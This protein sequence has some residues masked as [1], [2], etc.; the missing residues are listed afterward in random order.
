V[1]DHGTLWA[2]PLREGA[3]RSD[4]PD[5]VFAAGACGGLLIACVEPGVRNT[6]GCLENVAVCETE[7]PWNEEFCCPAGCMDIYI[8]HR[9]EGLGEIEASAEAIFGDE[10]CIPG[11]AEAIAEE[12]EL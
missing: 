1:N 5:P 10:G 8:A 4:E 9:K 6:R 3:R 2:D 7:E 12:V 11:M